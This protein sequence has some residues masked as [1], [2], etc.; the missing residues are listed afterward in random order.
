MSIMKFGE[1]HV[2]EVILLYQCISA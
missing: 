1:P 2:L